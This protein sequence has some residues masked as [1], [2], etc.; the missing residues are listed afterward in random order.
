MQKRNKQPKQNNQNNQN[1]IKI[2][3]Y[4]RL[5]NSIVE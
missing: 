5:T 4:C 2:I 1:K 3:F